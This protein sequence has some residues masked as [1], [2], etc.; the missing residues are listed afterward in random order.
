M[1]TAATTKACPVK[2]FT[3]EADH[4]RN[5]TLA[6]QNIKGCKLR[7]AISAQKGCTDARSGEERINPDQV[8]ALGQLPPL[9]GMQ[10]SVNP[11][12]LS[13]RITDP[14]YTDPELCDTVRKRMENM[15]GPTPS[16]LKGVKPQAGELTVH[17]MKTLC[18]E[19]VNIVE[20]GEGKVVK[21]KC[22]EHNEVE[23]MDGDFLLNPGSTIHNLQPQFEK[24]WDAYID[25]LN[26]SG[27]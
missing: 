25:Q 6:I 17:Q 12:E 20:A 27:G 10:L 22:P 26:R 8:M 3:I 2:P 14:L 19:L 23:K 18:R 9:K 15:P 5:A 24:D 21:G 13:Y 11:S 16:Q 7:S 4:P 1:N